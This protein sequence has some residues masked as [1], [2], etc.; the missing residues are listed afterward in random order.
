MTTRKVIKYE[1]LAEYYKAYGWLPFELI[2]RKTDFCYDKNYTIELALKIV[3]EINRSKKRL[4]QVTGYGDK[5]FN[6]G[7]LEIFSGPQIRKDVQEALNKG[8]EESDCVHMTFIYVGNKT[9][10][11]TIN[12]TKHSHRPRKTR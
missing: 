3:K 6:K 5:Q 4:I 7:E 9:V 1:I 8:L 12:K 2:A 11:L 10:E